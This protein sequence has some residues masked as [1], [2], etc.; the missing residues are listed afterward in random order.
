MKL[1]LFTL[2]AAA[3]SLL[4]VA[5]CTQ[6]PT[7]KSMKEAAPTTQTDSLSY[8][9]GLMATQMYQQMAQQ[10]SSL[11]TDA[12]KAEF[13]KA[14]AEGLKMAEGKSEAYFNGLVAGIQM[15]MQNRQ[16]KES[17]DLNM[18]PTMML[19]AF[20]YGIDNDSILKNND[21][22]QYI[23]RTMQSIEKKKQDQEIAAAKKQMASLKGKG[24]TDAGAD[25]MVKTVKPGT[26]NVLAAGDKVKVKM[27]VSTVKG[28][29][30]DLPMPETVVVG[31]TFGGTPLDG[32]FS[33]MKVGE[34]A[35]VALPSSSMVPGRQKQLGIEGTDAIIFD[36]TVVS[37]EGKVEQKGALVP[38]NGTPV[39]VQAA[40]AKK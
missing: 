19:S 22:M 5:S 21:A 14:V 35:Q 2:G 10:D 29:K 8:D 4:L 16:I 25:V 9:F 26:G 17:Y 30:L 38:A 34:T 39:Q 1:K 24:F 37:S 3:A 6:A 36:I 7:P 20:A 18:N 23:Q 28:K 12:G 32:V 13:L 27:T 33:K 31:Q 11:K 40:P 15:A